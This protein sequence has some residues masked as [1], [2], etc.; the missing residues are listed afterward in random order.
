MSEVSVNIRGS[1]SGLSSELSK[2]DQQLDSLRQKAETL[3]VDSN[4]L[5]DVSSQGK[6]TRQKTL[7]DFSGEIAIREQ[8]RIKDTFQ[9]KRQDEQARF[10]LRQQQ[11]EEQYKRKLIE[12]AS[13]ISD[14]LARGVE[15]FRAKKEF[16]AEQG[17]ESTTFSRNLS[18]IKEDE[19][20]EVEVSNTSLREAVDRLNETLT[21]N[22]RLKKE[23]EVRLREE[24]RDAG[25]LNPSNA[26]NP[27][28]R[29]PGESSGEKDGDGRGLQNVNTLAHSV[30]ATLR[31]GDPSSA[32][33]GLAAVS[34]SALAMGLAA[35]GVMGYQFVKA[36][37]ELTD[38]QSRLASITTDGL[39]ITE[40]KF[41]GDED[42]GYGRSIGAL[43]I[44]TEAYSAY[45]YQLSRSSGTKEGL[46]K[47]SFEMMGM[48]RGLGLND[49]ELMSASAFERSD[50]NKTTVSDNIADMVNIL[51]EIKDSGI[52]KDDYTQFGEKLAIQQ[53]ILANQYSRMDKTDASQATRTT[54]AFSAL[55]LTKDSRLGDAALGFAN[56]TL[57]PT[58][59]RSK[60]IG[61]D[62]LSE[63]HPEMRGR[64]DL[65][66]RERKKN[67]PEFQAAFAKRIKSMFGGRNS[68][69]GY[70]ASNQ[71]YSDLNDDQLDSIEQGLSGQFGD[72]MSGKKVP[73]S[74]KNKQ[75]K[76]KT[77]LIEKGDKNNSDLSSTV[78]GI[79][80]DVKRVAQNTADI[81]QVIRNS[82][83]N[84]MMPFTIPVPVVNPTK[85]GS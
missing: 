11:L 7:E 44:D 59:D 71:I 69:F 56:A 57:N 75:L 60:A 78:V 32:V 2:I 29:Q 20:D 74:D 80:N 40:S 58:N 66:E 28:P 9:K 83:W 26:D 65:L 19:D 35:I 6:V 14:P 8:E 34:G 53:K 18:R 33:S 43:G 25:R 49:N 47:R 63:M 21:E 84:P 77:D 24:A 12:N 38:K 81:V 67:S 82:G 10:N 31:S 54:A 79:Q 45:A 39:A 1:A 13:K 48:E 85:K 22:S 16:E 68:Q 61:Y 27:V 37:T 50:K 46:N 70:L 64:M 76:T 36:G 3:G 73:T 42:M 55:S 23:E 62:V 41:G 72:I 17:K 30:S 5:T 15:D 51:S 4:R 52:T